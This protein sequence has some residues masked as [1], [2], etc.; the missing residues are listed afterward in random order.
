MEAPDESIQYLQEALNRG[1][2]D[3]DGL[4]KDLD[5]KNLHGN[6]RFESLLAELRSQTALTHPH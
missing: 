5:L 6:P 1:Y 2:K 3:A 4:A